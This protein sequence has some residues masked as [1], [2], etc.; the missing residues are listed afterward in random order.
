MT[1]TEADRRAVG[2][3]IAAQIGDVSKI[4]V[5]DSSVTLHVTSLGALDRFPHFHHLPSHR[6]AWTWVDGILVNIILDASEDALADLLARHERENREWLDRFRADCERLGV[7][8]AALEAAASERE[9][10]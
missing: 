2:E 10:A 5:T 7:A 6:S 9:V 8:F 4:I 3:R 1:H